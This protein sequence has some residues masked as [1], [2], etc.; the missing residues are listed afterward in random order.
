MTV[1]GT[2][3]GPA[4]PF[5]A[6]LIG[7]RGLTSLCDHPACDKPFQKHFQKLVP[8]AFVSRPALRQFLE[9]GPGRFHAA[10]NAIQDLEAW[11]RIGGEC[12]LPD[13]A[14]ICQVDDQFGLPS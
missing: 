3:S 5:G 7:V 14:E 10:V 2:F 1:P 4:L 11:R 6:R 9:S 12:Y 13:D 8:D